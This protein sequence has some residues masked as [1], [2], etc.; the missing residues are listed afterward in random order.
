M[1]RVQRKGGGEIAG[2]GV[3]EVP[4][5]RAADVRHQVI[6]AAQLAGDLPDGRA[7]RGR[8]GDVGGGGRHRHAVAG[9]PPGGRGQAVGAAGD[10]PH[11]RAL[12]GQR[13]GDG[14]ADA[15]A[16][17]GDKGTGTTQAKIHDA[18]G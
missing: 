10:D 5:D 2:R 8:V 12:G 14:E 18:R 16:A 1:P 6:E 13:I 17:A 11:G 9:Q 7:E 4:A 3:G 15:P